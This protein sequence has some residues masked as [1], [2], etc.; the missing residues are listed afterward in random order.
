MRHNMRTA[1]W[2]MSTL[3]V[4]AATV[5][6]WVY[7]AEP[8]DPPSLRQPLLSG[9]GGL[10]W[11]AAPVP[12]TEATSGLAV[13]VNANGYFVTA[14]HVVRGCKALTAFSRLGGSSE[15]FVQALDTQND[16]AVV[17]AP[18][19][20][21]RPVTL[22]GLPTVAEDDKVWHLRPKSRS[23]NRA[24]TT[25]GAARIA[26]AGSVPSDSRVMKLFDPAGD[27]VRGFMP[28]DSGGPLFDNEG[29]LAGLVIGVVPGSGRSESEFV[30]DV[31]FALYAPLIAL[32]L[33][34]N[35]IDYALATPNGD[36]R[37]R[38]DVREQFRSST[39][40]LIC[41]QA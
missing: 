1:I 36:E 40:R 30:G 15:A 23:Q 4:S 34:A 2:A 5:G 31:G 26:G 22:R 20:L 39:I 6:L 8:A 10:D 14:G 38:H 32:F 35:N 18:A 3:V 11:A 17:V 7:L 24:S 41:E 9:L 21:P 27:G 13:A 28:G 37:V 19:L 12:R 33:D 29:A 25:I 16:L